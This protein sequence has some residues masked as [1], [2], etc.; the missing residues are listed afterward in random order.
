MGAPGAQS[1]I[2]TPRGIPFCGPHSPWVREPGR[3][4][5]NPHQSQQKRAPCGPKKA[6]PNTEERE[7]ALLPKKGAQ[8]VC[9]NRPPKGKGFL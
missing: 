1:A 7:G 3:G 9:R 8:K 4:S 6:P 2:K 5:K